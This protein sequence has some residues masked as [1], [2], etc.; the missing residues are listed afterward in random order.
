MQILSLIFMVLGYFCLLF[1]HTVNMQIFY[2]GT[3][4]S[5]GILYIGAILEA[6]E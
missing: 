1:D 4:L 3:V 2:L 5:N 6:K